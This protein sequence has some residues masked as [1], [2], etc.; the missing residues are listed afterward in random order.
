MPHPLS[1]QVLGR[2]GASAGSPR[3]LARTGEGSGN[4]SPAVINTTHT[5]PHAHGGGAAYITSSLPP[6][7]ASLVVR[8]PLTSRY[9][10]ASTAA[11]RGVG[12][13]DV[14][15]VASMVCPRRPL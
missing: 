11:R 3:N 4:G 12:C 13:R 1:R 5:C 10:A 2:P 8:V 15:A 6:W 9:V 7:S 14:A